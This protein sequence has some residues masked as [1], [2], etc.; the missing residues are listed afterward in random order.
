M[1]SFKS[2]LIAGLIILNILNL[3]GCN[4]VD[5]R[6]G[7]ESAASLLWDPY[8]MLTSARLSSIPLQTP[9]QK[10]YTL[11]ACMTDPAL[12]PIYGLDF[13]VQH[14]GSTTVRTSDT[15][16]ASTDRDGEL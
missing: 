1:N 14:N 16:A 11:K 5:S 9:T 13:A 15:W 2:N 3:L 6:N 8:P 10:S 7:T 12:Q 4:G